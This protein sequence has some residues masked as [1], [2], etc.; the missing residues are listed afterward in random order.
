M[1]NGVF[2]LNVFD[3]I[4]QLFSNKIDQRVYDD[5]TWRETIFYIA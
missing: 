1:V 3:G 5:I 2:V 4:V